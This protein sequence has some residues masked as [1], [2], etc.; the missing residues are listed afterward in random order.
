MSHGANEAPEGDPT[1]TEHTLPAGLSVGS[2]LRLSDGIS[3]RILRYILDEDL[4]HGA[5]LPSERELADRFGTSRPTISQAL[6]RLSLLGMVDIRRGS[7]VYVL[8]RPEVMVTASV[9][10]MLDMDRDSIGDLMEAR[11]W[12]ESLAVERAA[13]RSDGPNEEEAAS[14]AAALERLVDAH[15]STPRWIAADTVFHASVVDL[16]GNSFISAFYESVHTA[17]LES[18]YDE[19]VKRNTEPFWLH[20]TGP[21]Q[22]RALHEP[23]MMAVL[24]HDAEAAKTAVEAHH[25]VMLEHL[26]EAMGQEG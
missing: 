17:S 6:R 2:A 19:W 25:R 22:H 14:V 1:P 9:N 20:A 21:E 7:G 24:D 12:L 8:R 23:I 3:D 13:R 18:E 5:R 16:A 10:L 11:L 26:E 15:S 4:E